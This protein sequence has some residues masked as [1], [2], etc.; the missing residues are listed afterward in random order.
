MCGGEG[1][2]RTPGTRE[3][4]SDF[5][6]GALNRAL[7]PLRVVNQF[8]QLDRLGCRT[9]GVRFVVPSISRFHQ[10]VDCCYLMP[11][12]AMGIPHGHLERPVP[13]QFC[14]CA[15]ISPGRYES[16]CK[17]MAVAMP[18]CNPRSSAIGCATNRRRQTHSS[19]PASVAQRTVS[20]NWRSPD[21]Y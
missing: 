21:F 4:T 9:P 12:S 11:G 3:G 2:I 13:E 5:E 1:G 14:H 7:P 18:R 20:I 17:C 19:D 16:T 6:S 8:Y 10:M 15:Q